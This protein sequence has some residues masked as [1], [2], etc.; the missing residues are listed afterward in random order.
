MYMEAHCILNAD[1]L[2][3]KS[4]KHNLVS[5][6]NSTTQILVPQ[7]LGT[8]LMTLCKVKSNNKLKC[9]LYILYM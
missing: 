6:N 8:F 5:G 9:N 1:S 7:V 2:G 4:M 3:N